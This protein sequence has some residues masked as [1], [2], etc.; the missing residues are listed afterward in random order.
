MTNGHIFA[1][2]LEVEKHAQ[3]FSLPLIGHCTDSASNALGALVKMSTPAT[4]YM[5]NAELDPL[6]L[7][8]PQADFVFCAPFLRPC[9]PS[10]AYP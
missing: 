7:G 8:L 4:F 3:A 10:I 2:M 1:M 9:Y 6:F 5:D